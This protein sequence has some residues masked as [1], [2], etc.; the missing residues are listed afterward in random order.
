[1]KAKILLLTFLVAIAGALQPAQACRDCPFPLRLSDETWLLPSGL[2]EI[3]IVSYPRA[4]R[5]IEV[6][7]SLREVG[8]TT[9][10]A[11]GSVIAKRNE[12]NLFLSLVDLDGNSILAEI[13]IVDHSQGIIRARL[14][15]DCCRMQNAL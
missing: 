13:E 6:F 8:S 11:F 9:I 7:V 2:V 14:T 4:D 1:M 3:D 12:T 10:F 5:F 15:C